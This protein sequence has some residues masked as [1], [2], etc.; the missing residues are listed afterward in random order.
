MILIG[1]K[2]RGAAEVARATSTVDNGLGYNLESSLNSASRLALCSSIASG[3]SLLC[4]AAFNLSNEYLSVLS[5]SL[6]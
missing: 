1:E 4:Q 3:L 2:L 6:G 5:S